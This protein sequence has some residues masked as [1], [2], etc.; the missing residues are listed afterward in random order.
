MAKKKKIVVLTG[1]IQILGLKALITVPKKTKEKRA[2][3]LSANVP[4]LSTLFQVLALMRLRI[5]S[6]RRTDTWR[7]LRMLAIQIMQTLWVNY[8]FIVFLFCVTS[9]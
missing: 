7:E 4:K 2:K 3:R 5:M 9:R 6:M 8:L 1:D